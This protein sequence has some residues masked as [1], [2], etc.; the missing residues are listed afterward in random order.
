[1][2]PKNLSIIAKKELRGLVSERTI[3]LAVLL[4]LFIALFSSSTGRF[5]RVGQVDYAVANEVL[6]K[7]AQAEA[8]RRSGSFIPLGFFP[9]L[10]RGLA[11]GRA[12]LPHRAGAAWLAHRRCGGALRSDARRAGSGAE[13]LAAAGGA[14]ARGASGAPCGLPRERMRDSYAG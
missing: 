8:R 14:L 7:T 11:G 5:G 13:T 12:G 9:D 2:K 6:N 10:A 4:Q 3:L 1:M